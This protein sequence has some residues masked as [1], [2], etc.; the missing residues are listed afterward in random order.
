MQ[1]RS[2]RAAPAYPSPT[3]QHLTVL[4]GSGGGGGA[5]G[6]YLPLHGVVLPTSSGTP[7]DLAAKGIAAGDLYSNG[8]VVCVAPY[9]V[10]M[11]TTTGPYLPLH[12]VSL[13][14]STGTPA[15]LAAKGIVS[16]DLYNNGGVVC[17]A[18]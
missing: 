3:F 4:D 14:T 10:T 15:D 18:P 12:D 11:L 16:G 7:A 6:D 17:V 5:S 2:A 1:Q 9:A 8:G 13:P